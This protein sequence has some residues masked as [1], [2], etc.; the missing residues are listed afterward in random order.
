MA[1][2]LWDVIRARAMTCQSSQ[3]LI[4]ESFEDRNGHGA[5]FEVKF[6]KEPSAEQL[7]ADLESVAL[8]V[9]GSDLSTTE[10]PF[11]PTARCIND[12]NKKQLVTRSGLPRQRCCV[13]HLHHKW[14]MQ[15]PAAV[16]ENFQYSASTS[17]S[18]RG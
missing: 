5:V 14:A 12:T 7:F 9:E 4:L 11:E 10:M 17:V 2:A 3:E 6:E 16:R 15:S 1:M 13:C 8:A 18:L